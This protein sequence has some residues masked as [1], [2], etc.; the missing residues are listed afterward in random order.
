MRGEP[1]VC[2]AEDAILSF[3]RCGIDALVLEDFILDRSGLPALWDLE[4]QRA[5]ARRDPEGAVEH[6]VY[7]LL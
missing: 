7:T 4:A 2:S 6:L 1:I 3:V 5:L